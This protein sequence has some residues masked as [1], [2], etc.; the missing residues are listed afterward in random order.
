MRQTLP[1]LCFAADFAFMLLAMFY[2]RYAMRATLFSTALMRDD[3]IISPDIRILI[4]A[5]FSI[6]ISLILFSSILFCRR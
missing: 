5:V 4:F 2:V 3:I 1:L 6:A